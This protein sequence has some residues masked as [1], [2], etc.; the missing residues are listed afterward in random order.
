MPA[1]GT[2]CGAHVQTQD[3]GE[4]IRFIFCDYVMGSWVDIS[5]AAYAALRAAQ[6]QPYFAVVNR[7]AGQLRQMHVHDFRLLMDRGFS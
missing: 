3:D 1:A 2:H 7:A 6:L 5:S 4:H